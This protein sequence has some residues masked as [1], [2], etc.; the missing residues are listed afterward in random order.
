MQVVILDWRA[1]GPTRRRVVEDYLWPN[2][3][4][5]SF[6]AAA[7]CSDLNGLSP[8]ARERVQGRKQ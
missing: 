1:V 6:N 4:Q 5:I 7:P 8:S 2:G 3:G